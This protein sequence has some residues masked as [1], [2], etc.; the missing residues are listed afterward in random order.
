MFKGMLKN[1]KKKRKCAQV[2][3]GI[4]KWGIGLLDEDF[5]DDLLCFGI[6]NMSFTGKF[7]KYG[8]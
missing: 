4:I 8:K 7:E 1:L 2:F 5:W 6:D 3:G